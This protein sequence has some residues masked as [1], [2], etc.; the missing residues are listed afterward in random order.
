MIFLLVIT[1]FIIAN[2]IKLALYSHRTE[3]EIMQ[4]V[5]AQ[6]A[7]IYAPY[8]L[9]GLVQGV[10]GALLGLTLVFCV[11]LFLHDA[12][13]KT[14][15]IQ[16]VFPAFSFLSL[17]AAVFMV[18]SGALVGMCGSFLAVRRFLTES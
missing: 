13:T 3:V 1:G 9:E 11:Y 12:L 7:A 2:T 14:D 5:G 6:R 18:I 10:V 15:L 16:F 8:M 4:L 17:K